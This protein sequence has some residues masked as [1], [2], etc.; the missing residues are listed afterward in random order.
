[1][2]QHTREFN[3]TE[4]VILDMLEDLY[5]QVGDHARRPYRGKIDKRFVNPES[6]LG[7]IAFSGDLHSTISRNPG[8][9]EP[10]LFIEEDQRKLE[11]VAK[12]VG[13]LG[14]D[15][16]SGRYD[17][18]MDRHTLRVGGKKISVHRFTED[19][20][21]PQY[22]DGMLVAMHFGDQETVDGAEAIK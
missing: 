18:F 22:A 21:A 1:M 9:G 12:T 11:E 20:W 2:S 7:V 14:V 5:E 6:Y 4:V 17:H 3:G 15:L 8:V 19:E 16:Q 13:S 10:S